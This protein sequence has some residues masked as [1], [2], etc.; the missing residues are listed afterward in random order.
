MKHEWRKH[1]KEVYL[2][3]TE[4]TL[5]QLPSYKYYTLE[6]SGNPNRDEYKVEIEALYA[7]SY[8]IRM[9]HKNG[10]V[11]DN[12]YEYTVYPLEGLWTLD[13]EGINDYANNLVFSKDNLQYKIMIRQPEFVTEEL[14]IENI[15]AITKKKPNPNNAKIQFESM[16]DGLCIQMLHLGSYDA[17]AKSFQKMEEFALKKGYRRKHKYHREIYLS[18]PRKTEPEKNKTILRFEVEE[19]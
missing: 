6:G 10:E 14:A 4:P 15:E 2:P 9:M 18:D 1:E 19:I 13:S 5:I 16:S 12:F 17:E 11:P 3:K 7:M 8:G